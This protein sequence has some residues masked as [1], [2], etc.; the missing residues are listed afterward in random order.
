MSRKLLLIVILL[1]L[2]AGIIGRGLAQTQP[3]PGLLVGSW[4][5]TLYTDMVGPREGS[6]PALVTF[7]SDLTAIADGGAGTLTPFWPPHRGSSVTTAHGIWQP[8]PAVG[9]FYVHVIS[10]SID[11]SGILNTK[12]DFTMTVG[13]NETGDKLSGGYSFQMTGPGGD[14]VASGSGT[15]TGQLIPHALLP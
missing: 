2:A 8:S 14:I 11:S 7:T 4:E 3:A 13:L 9:N 5:L 6:V 10:L 15:V 1:C 12:A